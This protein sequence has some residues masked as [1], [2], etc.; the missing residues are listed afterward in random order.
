MLLDRMTFFL[1]EQLLAI[2]LATFLLLAWLQNRKIA[3]L[4][5]WSAWQWL[6]AIALVGF[7]LGDGLCWPLLSFAGCVAGALSYGCIATGARAFKGRP[8]SLSLLLVGP[9]AV[10]AAAAITAS[11]ESR[12]ISLAFGLVGALACWVAAYEFWHG[13]REA[14]LS[15]W[16]LIILLLLHGSASALAFAD[17]SWNDRS[18]DSIRQFFGLEVLLFLIGTSMLFVAVTKERA[19]RLYREA[20]ATDPLT[21][22]PNRGAFVEQAERMLARS[23]LDHVAVAVLMLDLDHFKSINDHYGHAAGDGVL[24]A[25]ADLLRAAARSKDAIGRLGGEEFGALLW[26][27]SSIQ[28]VEV[29]ARLRRALVERR[30]VCDGHAIAA[31]VSIGVAFDAVGGEGID[32]MLALADRALYRAKHNGRNCT[33][34]E[35]CAVDRAQ[36]ED[37]SGKRG[38]GR[39]ASLARVQITA[40]SA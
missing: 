39:L 17:G 9:G 11:I 15:R 31:T 26:D 3:C 35:L 12:E 29:A 10:V 13:R 4:A 22:I 18:F 21:G 6:S 2:V 38:A 32:R 37:G 19:E 24:I 30:I 1:V 5:W 28:A 8:V 16:P 27:V 23:G 14:L 20:A 40:P 34:L 7:A 25:F 36:P 33:E